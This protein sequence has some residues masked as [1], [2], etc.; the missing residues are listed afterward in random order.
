[1]EK[2]TLNNNLKMPMVGYGTY[3]IPPL[4]TLKHVGQAIRLGYRLIDTA[5]YYQNETGVGEAIRESGLERQEFFVTTKVQTDGY[6]ETKQSLDDSLRRF[7]GDYF[8]LVLIHWPMHD[9]LATYRALE[10]AYRDG[11]ILGIG[12]SNFNVPQVQEII[13]HADVKPVVDQ[14]ETHL[15][16]QQRR[17]HNYLAKVGMVHE[18]Y[19]PLGEGN[20]GFLDQPELK[21]IADKYHKTPAQ[22]TLR[23]LIQQGIVV[24][25]KSLNPQH[26]A[27]NLAIFDFNLSEDDMTKLSQL[28][29]KQAIDGWPASM[30]EDN[31]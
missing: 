13:D 24:I 14:I 1:M 20:D 11:K 15:L 3:Q 7:N 12:L 19:A 29:V 27:E 2:I 17:M 22:I 8:D 26:M 10:E 21:V 31:Y 6:L 16:W 23:F 4:E 25:P 28:D 5:Q 9:N 30:Q 18:A